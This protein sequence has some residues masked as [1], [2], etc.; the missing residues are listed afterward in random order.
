MG[1]KLALLRAVNVGARKVPMAELRELAASLGWSEVRTFIQSGNLIFS[2][3]GTPAKLEAAL[4]AALSERFGIDVPVIV[5]EPAA[6]AKL[7][8]ANPFPDAA[9]DI[10]NR[11]LAMV[12]KRPAAPDAVDKL[13]A[14]AADGE[15]I[16]AAGGAIWI[17][18]ADGVGRSKLTPASIDRACGAPTTG[19]NYRT[20]LALKE[21]LEA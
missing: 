16:A 10:P 14:R 17:V 7:A 19:R 11:L 3:S 1:R 21:M 12:P 15:G 20:V 13:A 4:E 6:W 18:Y 2:A 9:R 5:R 8:A